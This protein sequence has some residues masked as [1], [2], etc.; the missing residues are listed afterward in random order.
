MAN[1]IA[2]GAKVRE[3]R[4]AQ[5]MTL[6]ALA[7]TLDCS[8]P[9][10]SDVEHDL[11]AVAAALKVDVEVLRGLDPRCQKARIG[12]HEE[13]IAA[14]EERVARLESSDRRDSIDRRY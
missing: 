7:R 1:S 9:F 5:R 2:F 13:R 8:A 11:P 3:L 6:R 12:N 4:E 10:L 14:L